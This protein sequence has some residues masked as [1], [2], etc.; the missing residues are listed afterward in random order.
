MNVTEKKKKGK[1]GK[2]AKNKGTTIVSRK[3]VEASIDGQV[4]GIVEKALGCRFFEIN[5]LDNKKRRCKVRSKR[6][7]IELQNVVIIALREFDDN[8]ADIVYKYEPAEVRF[9]QKEGILPKSDVIGDG[10][11]VIEEDNTGFN[12]EDI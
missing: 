7:K 1:R 2:K 8:N 3:I 11:I 12:F 9:L 5:C 6:M 4:Y 10:G